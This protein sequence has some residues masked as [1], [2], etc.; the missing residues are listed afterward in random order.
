MVVL[1]LIPTVGSLR[2]VFPHGR[3]DLDIW[4]VGLS[5]PAE[6]NV[7]ARAADPDEHRV[8]DGSTFI[9]SG[10]LFDGEDMTIKRLGHL[11]A[12]HRHIHCG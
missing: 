9:V 4:L 1:R 3:P 5:I 6:Q 7:V 12:R 10:N 8:A 11:V 2:L